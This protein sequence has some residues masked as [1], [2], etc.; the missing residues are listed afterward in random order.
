[1]RG[2]QLFQTTKIQFFES[3]S[4]HYTPTVDKVKVVSDYKDT[5]FL[6]AIHNYRGVYFLAGVLFQTTKIQ[7]LKAIH[8]GRSFL[9]PRA[10]VVSDYKDTNF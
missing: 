5:N 10:S 3:N 8:N 9:S 4:Q 2:R 6:K 1:M 7:I